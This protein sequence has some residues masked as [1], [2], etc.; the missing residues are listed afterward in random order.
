MPKTEREQ[1]NM[2]SDLFKKLANTL[3]I[4]SEPDFQDKLQLFINIH[5]LVKMNK[6]VRLVHQANDAQSNNL[7]S[8]STVDSGEIEPKIHASS[9][10]LKPFTPTTI[11]E[12][13]KLI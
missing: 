3:S 11:E 7:A 4:L 13:V 12:K 6:P 2:A 8:S 9:D 10:P 5:D 1:Y